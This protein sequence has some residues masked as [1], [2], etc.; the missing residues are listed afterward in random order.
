[1]ALSSSISPH[2]TTTTTSN[3][4]TSTISKTP[5]SSFQ[6]SNSVSNLIGTNNNQI[7]II[8]SSSSSLL[9]SNSKSKPPTHNSI[10]TTTTPITTTNTSASAS[11]NS[12]PP[13]PPPL[14]L[15][16]P[17]LSD[18][19]IR[20]D[21]TSQ[22]FT[23][24]SSRISSVIL[25]VRPLPFDSES[26]SSLI[27]RESSSKELIPRTSNNTSSNKQHRQSTSCSLRQ[28]RSGLFNLA[29]LA[30]NKTSNALRSRHSS[31][32]ILDSSTDQITPLKRINNNRSKSEES[33]IAASKKEH[34]DT[35]CSSS[36]SSFSQTP[37]STSTSTS[38]LTSTS[39][40]TTTKTIPEYAPPT[41][42]LSRRQSLLGSNTPSQAYSNTAADTPP[43]IHSHHRTIN[44]SKMHQT[45]S[46]LLRM[47][48][49]DR[50]FT[51]DFKDLF[52]TLVVSLPLAGHRVRLTRIEHSFLSE[53]AINNL[54]S[55]KFSQSNRMP[56]P[57]DPS[58]IVTTTTTTTFSMA[59]EMARSVCQRFLDA[60]FI[61]SADGKQA[62][63]FSMKGSIWQLTP[64]GI[65]V[66]ERFCSK[67]GIQQRHVADLIASPRNTMQL[68]VLERDSATDKLSSDRSTIEVIFR[69]FVGQNGPNIKT[70]TSSADSDSLSEYKDGIAGVRMAGERKVGSP[71]R[72]VFQTFT[73]KAACDWLM[74][75]CTTVD[76]RE[77]TEVA[78]L[79]LEQ[80]LIWC[81][82]PDRQYQQQLPPSDDK[83][84]S[85]FQP[86][87]YA[88]YQLSQKGKDVINMTSRDRTSESDGT[89]AAIRAGVSRDSNTQKLDKILNDAALRLLFREN[90]RDTHCEEN[91]SFY[92]DVEEF[93]KSCKAAIRN[94]DP[95]KGKSG[96][97]L[98][99]VKETMASAYGIYNA[100]LAPGSPCELNI[101]HMLRNQLATRM[102]KAVG[103]D[104]AMVES[105]K[106]VTKLFEEAQ[107]SVFKL[108]AS[109]SV[110]KFMKS[111][112]YE[113]TLKNYDFDSIAPNGSRYS[114]PER[115]VSKSNR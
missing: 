64:K 27:V 81:V 37:T 78:S 23:K 58:R 57:K 66:L 80:E 67:N 94:V 114:L 16:L 102:T 106:E 20:E 74:D 83:K 45:S 76:R 69:R 111:S 61:E 49:D 104:A 2:T 33:I 24:D 110:P 29:L 108:M 9:T 98:D 4:T 48:S 41:D 5:N 92:L 3:N 11:S 39:T 63:D 14:P 52:A 82:Q 60:R 32:H 6:K 21:E 40:S 77:T 79:F 47:T 68:V 71:P 43:L 38:T 99:S 31:S 51:R 73:G 75:C 103:Q 59:R 100:F 10:T 35:G 44:S 50:P 72:T 87:K 96:G 28:N 34:T 22:I 112:K 84:D 55:L 93:L 53:E 89:S 12:S 101:D 42:F 95:T 7:Q 90:L 26:S 113:Q 15:P 107:L 30:R 19:F 56:D 13:S 86:T 46:R 97:S 91:L 65:H 1:M 8:P 115:S 85:R 70:S 88:Y 62:K 25:S 36:S 17:P 105:L 18:R 54:G 109:D